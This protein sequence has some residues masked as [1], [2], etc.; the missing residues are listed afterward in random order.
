[1]RLFLILNQRGNYEN[2]ENYEKIDA[3]GLVYNA[4]QK[5]YVRNITD[6]IG[7]GFHNGLAQYCLKGCELI[8]N[9]NYTFEQVAAMNLPQVK[10]ALK[11]LKDIDAK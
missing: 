2:Y 7:Y 9:H 11:A 8:S 10:R 6:L 4:M 3:L 5:G 1:M